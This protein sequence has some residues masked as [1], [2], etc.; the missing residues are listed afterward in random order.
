MAALQQ[1]QEQQVV[2]EAAV[3]L[4]E[5]QPL[6]ARVTLHQHHHPKVITAVKALPTTLLIAQMAVVAALVL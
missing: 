4:M 2:Q 6:E 1:P 5:L 3:V